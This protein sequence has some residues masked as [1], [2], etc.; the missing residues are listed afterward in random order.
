MT[1]M[2]RQAKKWWTNKQTDKPNTLPLPRMRAH[3]VT[4][5]ELQVHALILVQEKQYS[6]EPKRH[7]VAEQPAI[8]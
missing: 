1:L 3:G 7:K 2:H 6:V 4:N 5:T 8:S